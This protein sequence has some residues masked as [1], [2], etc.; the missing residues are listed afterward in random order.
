MRS[1]E[2]RSDRAPGLATVPQDA[3][4]GEGRYFRTVGLEALPIG[5]NDATE[6]RM[7]RDLAAGALR[8]KGEPSAF[9]DEAALDLGHEVQGAF[10]DQRADA[11]RRLSVST[12]TTR[13]PSFS[14]ARSIAMASPMSRATRSRR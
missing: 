14:T 7:V 11:V 13:A 2:V 12:A 8:L 6:R 1:F 3:R 9:R 4:P 5:R 10:H